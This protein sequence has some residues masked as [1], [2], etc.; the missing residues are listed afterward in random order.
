M[1]GYVLAPPVAWPPALVKLARLSVQTGAASAALVGTT[2]E[3]AT[4]TIAAS[5]LHARAPLEF[6]RRPPT[7]C[8]VKILRSGIGHGLA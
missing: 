4:T 2:N 3:A 5:D 8:A 7:A 1:E 6:N